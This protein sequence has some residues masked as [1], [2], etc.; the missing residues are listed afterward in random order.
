MNYRIMVPP[1]AVHRILASLLEYMQTCNADGK[2][3]EPEVLRFWVAQDDGRFVIGLDNSDIRM[4]ELRYIIRDN[5]V[6]IEQ[7]A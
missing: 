2:L 6:T 5:S 1:L 3:R 4:H 7:F